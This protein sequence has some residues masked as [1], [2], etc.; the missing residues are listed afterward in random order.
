MTQAMVGLL[1]KA[2]LAT[3]DLRETLMNQA[4]LKLHYESSN[5]QKI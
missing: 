3:F 5:T 1:D 2:T 4:F